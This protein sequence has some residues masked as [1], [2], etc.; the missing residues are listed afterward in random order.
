[1]SGL[2]R[3]RSMQKQQFYKH[4]SL[5]ALKEKRHKKATSEDLNNELQML[6]IY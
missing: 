1:M 6:M 2:C 5:Q 4:A 3:N